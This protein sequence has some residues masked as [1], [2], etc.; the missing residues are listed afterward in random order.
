MQLTEHLEI[1]GIL[2][3]KTGLKIGG[4]KEAAGIGETDNPIIRHPITRLPYVPGSSL[5][6]KM[7][8]L[9]EWK[10]RPECQNSGKPCDCGKC[11]VCELFGS[12][13]IRTTYHPTRL[14][15]RDALLT[16]ESQK[17]LQETLPGSFIEEKT[18][19]AMNRSTGATRD[20]SLRQQERIPEGTT[21]RFALTMR[22][23]DIDK[24]ARSR[25]LEMVAEAVDMLEKDYLGG[26]GT[27]GYGKVA[28]TAND[29]KTPLSQEIKNLAAGKAA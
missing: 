12:N 2:T 25:Y 4:T 20:R 14:I 1:K 15:F 16:E 11:E 6:G 13:N 29:G 21:F 19:I 7:R 10:Y 8:S 18:E 17:E 3:C 9:L 5:K 23:F 22:L 24:Q 26:S 28:L 27:R